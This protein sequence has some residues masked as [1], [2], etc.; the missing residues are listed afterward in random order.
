MA[1]KVK[2]SKRYP[3][4]GLHCASCAVK[5]ETFVRKLPG[6]KSAA[7][8]YA[9][10]SLKVEYYPEEISP[11]EL[12]QAVQTIG[13]DIITDEENSF[14][15]QEAAHKESLRAA[16]LNTA[17]AAVFSVPL[18]IISMTFMNM[19]YANYIMMALTTPVM[20]WF[21]RQFPAGAFRQLRHGS[22]GMD[23]LVAL[24]TGIAYLFSI[25]ITFF[26]HMF[27]SQGLH[28][29]V[30]FEA[31]A[32]II[33]FILLGRYL[34]ERAKLSTSAA[35][36]KLIGLQSK[37]VTVVKGS[38]EYIEVPAAEVKKDDIIL[39]KSGLRI[40]V[41]GTVV[42]GFTFV[43]ESMLT[44]EAVPAEKTVGSK[45]FAG[46]INHGGSIHFRAE[47]V[48]S[49]TMLAQ[50]IR[51]VREAQGSKAPVQHLVD[52]IAGIFV[53]VVIGIAIISG[54]A[55][56]LLAKENALVHSLLSVVTVLIIA[57][58]CALGLATPTAIMVGIGKGADNGILVKDAESLETALKVDTVVLDKTGT[59]TLGEPSVRGFTWSKNV[60]AG[61]YGRILH[62]IEKASGHPLAEPVV[63]YLEDS[64]IESIGYHV[65]TEI[66]SGKGIKALL[67]GEEWYVGN[68]SL[69]Q[70]KGVFM[71]DELLES[72]A[73]WESEAM[74]IS[75][76]SDASRALAAIGV[77]DRIRQSSADAIRQL[78]DMGIE[79]YMLTGDNEQSAAAMAREAGIKNFR[80]GM[81]PGDKDD[82]IKELRARGKV[83]A[84]AGDGINDSQALA[85]ADVSIAMGKG[86]DIA[87]DVAKMTIVSSDLMKIPQAFKL[88]RLTVR[89][90]RQ[91]LFWA[92][93][94]NI[95][96]I[97]LAAG[98]LYPFTGFLLNPMIAGAAMALSSVSVVTNSLR[99]RMKKL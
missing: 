63:R 38:G 47:R 96:G 62:A 23:T 65:N 55:W 3:V 33:T 54:I 58:P 92:F 88:S 95:I 13:Y 10:A 85:R 22:A 49:E 61:K 36:R 53:P 43:D 40:P 20:F 26:P 18:L 99:L 79:V 94:Y 90:I 25:V 1:G 98:V 12:R 19:P 73:G 41:D 32:V 80:A 48:G 93:I 24:S 71:P 2:I 74:S 21:G 39:V 30:Y 27:S 7:V 87:I 83:V 89:T 46:T 4:T 31:S 11:P 51:M 76:F 9:D 66:L 91:N 56:L 72:S 28:G 59:I 6:I 44:G 37:T 81:L 16:L 82:F 34:E 50:I 78:Q 45:V 15:L 8:N 5:T 86:S 75:F 77:S 52:K 35:L 17:G 14:E 97:P 42:S 64:G 68:R 67:D 70:E 60:F 84:M 29:H 69:M 57:C